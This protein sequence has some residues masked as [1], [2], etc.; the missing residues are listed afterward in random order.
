MYMNFKRF[1]Q[2]CIYRVIKEKEKKNKILYIY[3]IHNTV[4]YLLSLSEPQPM[5]TAF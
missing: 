2:K 3:I 4:M 5:T 1:N